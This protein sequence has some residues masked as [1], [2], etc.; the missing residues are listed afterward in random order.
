MTTPH[1][2]GAGVESPAARARPSLSLNLGTAK[3]MN[4]RSLSGIWPRPAYIRLIGVGN[5]SKASSNFTRLPNFTC[6]SMYTRHAQCRL[7][8][9][10]QD[11]RLHRVHHKPGGNLHFQCVAVLRETSNPIGYPSYVTQ[12]C[13]RR[14]SGSLGS[15]RLLVGE[16]RAHHFPKQANTRPYQPAARWLPN[17]QHQINA[18]FQQ[19]DEPDRQLAA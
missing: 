12:S 10:R 4:T 1:S 13:D 7:P 2:C 15:P 11:G 6:S 5:G 17:S 9:P 14:S 8:L 16:A 18:L 19:I 3:S